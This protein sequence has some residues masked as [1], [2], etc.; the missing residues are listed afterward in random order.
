MIAV[1]TSA[2]IAILFAETDADAIQ[3]RMSVAPAC[4]SA[5]SFQEA[6]MVLA[7]RLRDETVW[8]ELDEFIRDAPIEIV[9]HDRELAEIS[10][11]AFIRF[12]KG[13]HPARLN[14]GDCAAYALAKK[15]GIPLLFKGS[16]FAHTDIVPALPAPA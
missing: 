8:Q 2:L 9:A 6:S 3:R 13:R 11:L 10:R 5:V 7:G 16:D 15:R 12:G 4:L 1:D 14:R